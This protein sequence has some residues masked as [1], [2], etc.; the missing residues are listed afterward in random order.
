MLFFY[1]V[2]FF[3]GYIR[4]SKSTKL[5]QIRIE[6]LSHG[7]L[8][9]SFESFVGDVRRHSFSIILQDIT[10]SNRLTAYGS[11]IEDTWIWMK[12]KEAG[13]GNSSQVL[14]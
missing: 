1:I 14:P 10:I 4:Q 5:H 7:F 8:Y 3:V 11:T 13:V 12:F 9:K 6:Y 2:L